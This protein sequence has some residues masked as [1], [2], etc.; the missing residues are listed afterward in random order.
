MT[1]FTFALMLLAQRTDEALR[2][3]RLRTPTNSSLMA[4]LQRRRRQLNARLRRSLLRPAP[5]G[6]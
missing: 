4:R 6:R 5:A 2:A 3:E 1:P